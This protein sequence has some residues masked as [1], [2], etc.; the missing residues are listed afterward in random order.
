MFRKLFAGILVLFA[1]QWSHAQSPLPPTPVISSSL[2]FPEQEK[3]VHGSS[4]VSLPNGDLLTCWFQGSGE[5]TADDVRV[6]GARLKKGDKK[7]S[8]PFLMADTPGIPDCNPVLFLN[9]K[10]KLFLVWIAVL[11]NKWEMSVLRYKTSV[12]YTKEGAP[13]WNWQDNILF[14]PKDTFAT[15][16]AKKFK[17]LPEVNEAWAAFAEKYDKMIVDASKDLSKRSL[18]WM[19]RIKPMIMNNGRILLPLYS[20]GYNF[21]LIAISDDDGET[22]RP[23]LPI[24]TRGGIQPALALK[25]NGALIAYMRDNGA[26][27]TR[28]TISESN[29]KGES[30]T[31]AT[32]GDIPNPGSSVEL[33]VLQDGRWAFV[34][35]DV[36]E[37]RHRLCLYISEDEGKSWKNKTWLEDQTPKS[38][39]F[40]YPA[41]IQTNDGILHITYSHRYENKGASIKYVSIDPRSFKTL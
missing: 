20:D 34:G 11:A 1:I 33:Q 21:S 15:E 41:M 2:I 16:T 18:G 10:G 24:I 22:W 4:I 23:S 30:W 14:K 32:K 12:N 9:G 3:H 6:M 17:E 28:V 36:D 8:P 38:A 40:S 7:W 39:N 29:D 37:G 31:A 13:V 35:N 26:A 5:R 19:T 25:K 27:P